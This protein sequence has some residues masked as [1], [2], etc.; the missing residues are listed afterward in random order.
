MTLKTIFTRIG[1][2]DNAYKVYSIVSRGPLLIAHIA[3]KTRIARPG[4]YRAITALQQRGA[5]IRVRNGKRVWYEGSSIMHIQRL[6]REDDTSIAAEITKYATTEL[7]DTNTIKVLHGSEGIRAVFDD[8][9]KSTPRGGVV[10]R[11]T[12][13]QNLHE[14]NSYLSPEYRK[15]RDAKRLER[16]VI[17]NITSG[18]QKKPRLERFVKF[19][20]TEDT[21]FRQNIVQIIYADK[22]AIVDLSTQKSIIITNASFVDFQKTLFTKLYKKL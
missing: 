22:V 19:L 10:Y 21:Q 1:F 20:S 4:V 2:S 15:K 13:E 8:V 14:V 6:F 16:L 3:H 12:S 9:V 7:D 17:S 5:V 11:Y 18:N